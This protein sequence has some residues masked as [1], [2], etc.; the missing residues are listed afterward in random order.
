[1]QSAARWQSDYVVSGSDVFRRCPNHR[2]SLGMALGCP[3]S[4]PFLL[5]ALFWAAGTLASN[6]RSLT[7]DYAKPGAPSAIHEVCQNQSHRIHVRHGF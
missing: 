4:K 1:M 7:G 6:W 3:W 5:F 2:R